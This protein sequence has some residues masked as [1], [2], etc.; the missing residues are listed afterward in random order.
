MKQM[1]RRATTDWD[2]HEPE[3]VED[4]VPDDG[5]WATP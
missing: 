5:L 4:V 3:P 2:A 1:L